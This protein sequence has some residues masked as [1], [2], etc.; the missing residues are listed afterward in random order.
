[1]FF[2]YICICISLAEAPMGN[3]GGCYFYWK[4]FTY[5]LPRLFEIWKISIGVW[6]EATVDALWCV[7]AYRWCYQCH[8]NW[9]LLVLWFVIYI[10]AWGFCVAR[11][12]PMGI[13]EPRIV[14]RVTGT[15]SHAF[16]YC[17]ASSAFRALRFCNRR[18]RKTV[19]GGI[20]GSPAKVGGII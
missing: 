8:C 15:G 18:K 17:I 6:D 3:V 7:Y 2:D 1:M 4:A 9:Q 14:G 16:F 10:S 11:S 13:P 5:A 12:T 19:N 20:Y